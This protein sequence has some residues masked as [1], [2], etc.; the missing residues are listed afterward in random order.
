[1]CLSYSLLCLWLVLA[2]AQASFLES[3]GDSP[4]DSLALSNMSL[5]G[6]NGSSDSRDIDIVSPSPVGLPAPFYIVLRV[7]GNMIGLDEPGLSVAPVI[8]CGYPTCWGLTRLGIRSGLNSVLQGMRRSSTSMMGGVIRSAVP[9]SAFVSVASGRMT[10]SG[11]AVFN[12]HNGH[13]DPDAFPNLIVVRVHKSRLEAREALK[14]GLSTHPIETRMVVGGAGSSGRSRDSWLSDIVGRQGASDDCSRSTASLE[15]TCVWLAGRHCQ[16][17]YSKEIH[18]ADEIRN[19]S[20]IWN[21]LLGNER[22]KFVEEEEEEEDCWRGML[23]IEAREHGHF[24]EVGISG[25]HRLETEERDLFPI[26]S[27]DIMMFT[28]HNCAVECT[29]QHKGPALPM[30]KLGARLMDPRRSQYPWLDRPRVDSAGQDIH[31]DPS[32]RGPRLNAR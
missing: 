14:M 9:S 30:M 4:D 17:K 32:F 6:A 31:F 1:M 21:P 7:P 18:G 13:P 11:G 15:R 29:F 26:M 23:Q 5:S 20:G 22:C 2:F 27:A 25:L 19:E 24:T 10:R 28:V 12:A 8:A 3:L 16:L